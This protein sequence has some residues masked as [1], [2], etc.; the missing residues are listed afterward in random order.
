MEELTYVFII[1]IIVLSLL[2]ISNTYNIY[3]LSKKEFQM[4]SLID[5]KEFDTIH[6]MIKEL[7]HEAIVNGV[8]F[9]HNIIV[10]DV[11][12]MNDIDKWYNSNKTDL[13]E[14][15]ESVRELGKIS[16]EQRNKKLDSSYL[17]NLFNLDIPELTTKIKALS[18]SPDLK[19]SDLEEVMEVI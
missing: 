10:N 19:E 17:S 8:F 18:D 7:Y 2:V 9:L 14:L 13:F 12:K 11:I 15:I 3:T 1:I 4:R 6:P 16:I 5:L